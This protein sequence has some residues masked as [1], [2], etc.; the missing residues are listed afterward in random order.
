MNNRPSSAAQLQELWQSPE[1]VKWLFTGDSISQGALHTMGHR[2]YVEHFDE[3]V[4]WEL[5][6]TQ[7]CVIKTAS[8]GWRI[9]DAEAN[10][11]NNVLQYQPGVVFL[12]FGVNDCTAGEE[13]LEKF[14]LTYSSALDRIVSETPALLVLQTPNGIL[15]LD[16]IRYRHLPTYI[17]IVEEIAAERNILL[18]DHAAVWAEAAIKQTM[19]YWLS[20]A[21]HPN[22][23]G[24]RVMAHT[25]LQ[26]IG[27][28]DPL[29]NVCRYFVP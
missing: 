14:R 25:V 19:I 9:T 2:D 29:S 18:I 17:K 8:N 16:E 10:L 20:D 12:N 23:Y 26:T 6:R 7:D 24:H 3:R 13:G 21:V 5:R 11:H 27:L 15:P 4:R 1:P 22:E 28:Y